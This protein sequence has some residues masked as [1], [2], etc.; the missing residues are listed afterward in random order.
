MHG[1]YHMIT[2]NGVVTGDKGP[3]GRRDSLSHV[4]MT[5]HIKKICGV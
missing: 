1:I 3:S 5:P 2:I 4:A